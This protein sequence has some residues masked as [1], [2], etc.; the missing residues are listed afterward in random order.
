MDTE[1]TRHFDAIERLYIRDCQNLN[2]LRI[3]NEELKSEVQDLKEEIERLETAFSGNHPAIHVHAD[4]DAV[5]TECSTCGVD[6]GVDEDGCCTSCGR[7]AL[8]F[9]KFGEE[10]K[11]ALIRDGWSN[12]NAQ[13]TEKSE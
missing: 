2:V 11:N 13:S 4:G 7:D 6:V 8:R 5:W 3:T 12:Q 1:L 9:G 10:I